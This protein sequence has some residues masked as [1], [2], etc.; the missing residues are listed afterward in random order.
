MLVSAQKEFALASV[1]ASWQSVADW[2]CH[3]VFGTPARRADDGRRIADR[4]AANSAA[5]APQPFLYELPVGTRHM[6]LWMAEAQGA[7]AWTDD[8]TT[9]SIASAVDEK[10]GGEFIWFLVPQPKAKRHRR[11]PGPC[12]GLLAPVVA[13]CVCARPHAALQSPG[14]FGRAPAEVAMP[15]TSLVKLQSWTRTRFQGQGSGQVALAV[16]LNAD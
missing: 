4:P 7:T 14:E 10:G 13:R 11:P 9:A 3:D 2:V 12:A 6:V 15:C 8:R 1:T 16:G 5:L